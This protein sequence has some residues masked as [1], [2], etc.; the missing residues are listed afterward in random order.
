MAAR[1]AQEKMIGELNGEFGLA[2]VPTNHYGANSARQQL[3]ILA[4]PDPRLSASLHARE[5]QSAPRQEHVPQSS[6]KYAHPA[7]LRD[8]TDGWKEREAALVREGQV[9]L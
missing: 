8:R 6:H 7:F 9:G 4:P 1:G 2:V 5:A 3:S